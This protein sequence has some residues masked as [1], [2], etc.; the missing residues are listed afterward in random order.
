MFP[1]IRLLAC[2]SMFFTCKRFSLRHV[3]PSES[4]VVPFQ[5]HFSRVNTSRCGLVAKA[6][7]KSPCGIPYLRLLGAERDAAGHIGRAGISALREMGHHRS[8]DG[9][10][11]PLR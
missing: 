2:G 9:P 7:V 11:Y 3:D 5:V 8:S 1:D 4:P 10:G 6:E